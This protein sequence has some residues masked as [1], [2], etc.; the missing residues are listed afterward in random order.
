MAR[1]AVARSSFES[2]TFPPVCCVT[3]NHTDDYARW[4]FGRKD[5][6]GTLP[7]S[8][9][10][11]R[12]IGRMRRVVLLVG[13]VAVAAFIVGGDTGE[14]L[15]MAV[16]AAVG[17]LWLLCAAL[18]VAR[19]PNARPLGRDAIELRHVHPTFV[20]TIRDAW[21]AQAGGERS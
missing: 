17:I 10:A 12:R 9:T 7:M 11:Q 14:P 3:G 4:R 8:A 6:R 1:I 2:G 5:V 13:V 19:T 20:E 18:A 21:A 15:V 16:G